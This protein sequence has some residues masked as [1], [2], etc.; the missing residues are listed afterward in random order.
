[1][2]I[3]CLDSLGGHLY[4]APPR[5]W[6][7][8]AWALAL[9]VAVTARADVVGGVQLPEG[10][11]KVGENRYRVPGDF[12]AAQKY[13][14]SVY[15]PGQFPRKSIVNQPG[16]KAV[17]ISNPSGKKWEGINIYQANDEVRIFVIVAP[18]P[19]AVPVQKKDGKGKK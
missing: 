3:H 7:G 15:P 18:E 9:L 16:V 8:A 12:E 5:R 4:K 13:F 17:H 14:K 1:M 6:W 11:E 2:K 19:K 10:A